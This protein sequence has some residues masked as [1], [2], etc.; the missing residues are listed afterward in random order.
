MRKVR[1]RRRRKNRLPL[2]RR[3]NPTDLTIPTYSRLRNAVERAGDVG[4]GENM[5]VDTPHYLITVVDF[6]A[7][8]DG[9]SNICMCVFARELH[10]KRVF[11]QLI[12][13]R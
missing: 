12:L 9:G 8:G 2:T 7:E 11:D 10:A 13:P 4:S 5:V 3:T 6:I 1:E